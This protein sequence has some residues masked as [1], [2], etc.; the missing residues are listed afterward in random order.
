MNYDKANML[1]CLFCIVIL[2]IL[3]LVGCGP[4]EVH[5]DVAPV[6]G[7]VN[8]TVT[9]AVPTSAYIPFFTKLCPSL[10]ADSQCYNI[11]P[12]VC[13]ACLAEALGASVGSPNHT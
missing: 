8:G 7:T 9:L 10:T 13:A 1:I 2:G 12:T 6:T 5:G 11:D 3:G 4:L